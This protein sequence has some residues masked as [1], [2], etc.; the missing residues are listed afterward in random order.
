MEDQVH[1]CTKSGLNSTALHS[2]LKSTSQ[3]PLHEHDIIYTSP[4]YA[5]EHL[6][7]SL[8]GTLKSR[9]TLIV[10]DEAHCLT[11]WG[12]TSFR[13]EYASLSDL[14]SLV[15]HATALVTTGTMTPKMINIQR[16]MN[17]PPYVS[18]PK[19]ITLYASFLGIKM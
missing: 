11:E 9:I 17:E 13:P 10:F 2:G 14:L 12:Q 15:P 19:F 7:A 16:I 3:L 8:K 4:E 18:H 5:L 1:I 6:R